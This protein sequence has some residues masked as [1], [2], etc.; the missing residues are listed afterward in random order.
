MVAQ[1][2]QHHTTRVCV[3]LFCAGM[4]QHHHST[5][6]CPLLL[7]WNAIGGCGVGVW[8]PHRRNCWKP[9]TP[10]WLHLCDRFLWTD[11]GLE[12]NYLEESERG[13]GKDAPTC[14]CL[15]QG[16]LLLGHRQI[17]FS[18]NHTDSTDTIS[19]EGSIFSL[20]FSQ[21]R[22]ERELGVFLFQ[23]KDKIDSSGFSKCQCN[24]IFKPSESRDG[25]GCA[26]NMNVCELV[27]DSMWS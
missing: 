3:L 6:L 11:S 25:L 13:S 17:Y 9:S 26:R 4:T 2:E 10:L 21:D 1:Q 24:Y 5:R 15:L 23:Q 12:V 7:H 19:N 22:R 27:S 8:N 14:R 18:F 16:D 20:Q